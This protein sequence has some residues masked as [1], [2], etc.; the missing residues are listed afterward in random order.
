MAALT[1]AELIAK[2][3]EFPPDS[4]VIV[5][6]EANDGNYGCWTEQVEVFNVRG[7]NLTSPTPRPMTIIY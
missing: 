3:S 2:L 5:E 6:Y 4:T 1:V 7:G